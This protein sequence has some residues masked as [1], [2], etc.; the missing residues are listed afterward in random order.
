MEL[1]ITSNKPEAVDKAAAN[2]PAATKAIQPSRG[3]GNDQTR[4]ELERTGGHNVVVTQSRKLLGVI[5][6]S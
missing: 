1:E 2:P 5:C 4:C 6:V 3:K